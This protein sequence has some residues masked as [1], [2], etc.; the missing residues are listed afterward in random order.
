M[1]IVALCES[2]GSVKNCRADRATKISI[3]MMVAVAILYFTLTC[4]ILTKKLRQYKK[5]PYE[6][7]QV[8]VVFYRLQVEP[9]PRSCWSSWT[10]VLLVA[11]QH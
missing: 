3:D 8:A 9:V 11:I 1:G 10:A 6:Q 5:M 4:G 7:I 2:G